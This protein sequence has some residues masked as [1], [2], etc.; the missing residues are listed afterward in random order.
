MTCAARSPNARRSPPPRTVRDGPSTLHIPTLH[1]PT[2]HIA[3]KDPIMCA[4]ITCSACGKPTWTGCGQHIEDA[5]YGV[6][7]TDRCTCS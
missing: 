1:I 4:R 2:L 5:L 6:P 3:R 7:E